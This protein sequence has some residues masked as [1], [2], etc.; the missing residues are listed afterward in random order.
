MNLNTAYSQCSSRIRVFD[1]L[2]IRTALP[3][4]QT[5]GDY[6]ECIIWREHGFVKAPEN[7]SYEKLACMLWS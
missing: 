5:N 1:S 6:A 2:C 3:A 7:L 4:H